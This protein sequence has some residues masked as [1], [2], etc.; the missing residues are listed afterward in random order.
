MKKM[1]FIMLLF[2]T[3]F[4]MAQKPSLYVTVQSSHAEM[5]DSLLRINAALE[6]VQ[7]ELDKRKNGSIVMKEGYYYGGIDKT[8]DSLY[9][10]KW[11]LADKRQ[12]LLHA[13]ELMLGLDVHLT[14]AG[15][16][17]RKAYAL[18]LVGIAFGITGGVCLG[19]GIAK[20]KTA[21]M[22]S[23]IV[24]GAATFSCFIGAYACHFKSGKKLQLAGNS[25]TYSF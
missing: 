4:T 2:V 23:G 5:T 18:E 7:K 1:L 25:I 9:N 3:Q 24:A 22:A 19:T 10:L 12:K 14:N 21:I 6:K 20:D 15:K 16:Y 8:I 17:V 13:Q 11:K